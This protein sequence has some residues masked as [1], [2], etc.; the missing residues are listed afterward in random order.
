MFA[1]DG[2]EYLSDAVE[3]RMLETEES[4]YSR[5]RGGDAISVRIPPG[6]RALLKRA[7]HE[8]EMGMQAYAS[9]AVMAFIVSDLGLD[10]AETMVDEY[11]I[12]VYGQAPNT[13]R[14]YGGA[15][16]GNWQVRP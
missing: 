8:R 3:Q 14:P 9:R 1:G 7:A 4:H 2:W 12:V 5:Y 13:R 16:F 11:P 6:A 15:G 10:W